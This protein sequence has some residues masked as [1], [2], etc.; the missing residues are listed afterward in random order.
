MGKEVKRI[1][2]EQDVNYTGQP[3]WRPSEKFSQ[4][5]KSH[6]KYIWLIVVVLVVLAWLFLFWY[7]NN[8][9]A[10]FSATVE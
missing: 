10:P 5:V 6:W 9:H 3:V 4:P 1:T 7:F 2:K 8:H